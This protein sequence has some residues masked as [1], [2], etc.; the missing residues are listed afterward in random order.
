MKRVLKNELESPQKLLRVL[1]E[2]VDIIND[3][4]SLVQSLRAQRDK[5][6]AAEKARQAKCLEA[7]AKARAKAKA[8][9]EAKRVLAEAEA[10]A[11]AEAETRAKAE[12]EARAKAEAVAAAKKLL[13]ETK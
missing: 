8:I 3:T 4:N 2:M 1:N 6:I 10:K 13:K 12:A 7:E 9:Q 11:K 5:R